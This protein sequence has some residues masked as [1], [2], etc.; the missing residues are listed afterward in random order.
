MTN[1]TTLKELKNLVNLLKVFT[2]E[3]YQI[4]G[5]YGGYKLTL[6]NRDISKGYISKSELYYQIEMYFK[7][8]EAGIKKQ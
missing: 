8:L 7:G 4:E 1:K 5:A 6:D 3:N 2:S